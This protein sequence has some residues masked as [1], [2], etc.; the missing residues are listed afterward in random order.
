[1]GCGGEGERD[2]EARERGSRGYTVF[3]VLKSRGDKRDNIERERERES[4]FL[5]LLYLLGSLLGEREREKR[6]K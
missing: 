4:L 1:M 2:V 3:G 6:D 5:G